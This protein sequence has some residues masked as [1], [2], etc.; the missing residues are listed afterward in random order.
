MH[1]P[2]IVCIG[3]W[4]FRYNSA[5]YIWIRTK[6]TRN[7]DRKRIQTIIICYLNKVADPVKTICA[8]Q[9]PIPITRQRRAIYYP[10]IPIPA[11]IIRVAVEGVPSHQT[12][13]GEV[14]GEILGIDACE[15]HPQQDENK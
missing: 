6:P 9:I 4:I 15:H 1:W 12:V 10:I 2:S 7:W 8:I 3:K 13:G 14:G 11:L 5:A